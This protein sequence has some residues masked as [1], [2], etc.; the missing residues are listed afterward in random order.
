MEHYLTPETTESEK[1]TISAFCFDLLEALKTKDS[2]LKGK[3]DFPSG[4]CGLCRNMEI[5]GKSSFYLGC[6]FFSTVPFNGSISY[7]AET[8]QGKSFEN[9]ERMKFIKYWAAKQ[10]GKG[11]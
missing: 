6:M 2:K 4:Y 7:I 9:E 8:C 10:V 5:W 3:Y 11:E 1:Q